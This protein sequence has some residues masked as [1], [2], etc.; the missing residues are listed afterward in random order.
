V[1]A[2][3]EPVGRLRGKRDDAF[4]AAAVLTVGCIL[5]ALRPLAVASTQGRVVLFGATYGAIAIA[6]IAV[7]AG[8]DRPRLST[9]WAFGIGLAAL[10]IAVAVAAPAAG[11]P[12]G[13]A[14][15]PLSVLAAVAEEALFRRVAYARLARFGALVAISGSAL[16]FGLVHVPAYGLAALP[17]D[18]GAGL[19]FGW[20]RW[21]SGT[22]T[23]PATTHALANVM[24]VLR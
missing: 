4:A 7:P 2:R 11:T 16:L 18:V 3:A 1:S 20:Q 15:L 24:V 8:R 21:A 22:W 19:L 10:A 17:V 9:A 14:A 23:V 5:L 13:V 12:W 6:S